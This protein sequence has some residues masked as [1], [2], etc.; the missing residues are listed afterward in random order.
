MKTIF[1]SSCFCGILC[2]Q[3]SLAEQGIFL[4][5]DFEQEAATN[6]RTGLKLTE[7]RK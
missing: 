5:S 3:L 7:G 6:T 2:F 4:R 1:V